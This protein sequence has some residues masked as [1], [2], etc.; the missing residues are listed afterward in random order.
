MM[1]D[2]EVSE[3]DDSGKTLSFLGMWVREGYFVI[4]LQQEVGL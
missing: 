4:G 1:R 2:V 3:P